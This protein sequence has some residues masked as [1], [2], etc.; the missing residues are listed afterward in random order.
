MCGEPIQC[1]HSYPDRNPNRDEHSNTFAVGH[2]Y[3]HGYRHSLADKHAHTHSHS[4]LYTHADEHAYAHTFAD[5]H[6]FADAY[7]YPYTYRHS[8]AHRQ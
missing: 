8:G 1:P 4:F 5:R 2:Q 3:T 6:P 7:K